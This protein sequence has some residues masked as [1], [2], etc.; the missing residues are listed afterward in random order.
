MNAR[1]DRPH[2]TAGKRLAIAALG[3][4][5]GLSAVFFGRPILS[6]FSRTYVGAGGDPTQA[7]WALVWWPYALRHGLNPFFTD[8]IWAPHGANLAWVTGVPG[9]SLMAAPI[10]LWAGPVAAY[11]ILSLLAPALAATMAYLVCRHLT[12]R[13]WPSLL[14][15]YL[16][17]FSPYE[18][19]HLRG[20][21]NLMLIF[22]IPLAAYLV[23]LRL[24]EAIGPRAFALLLGGVL[25]TQF[26]FSSE[27]F[28]TLSVFGALALGL[29][30]V[31][32]PADLKPRLRSAGVLILC[33]YGIALILLSPYLYS[34]VAQGIPR[35]P[36]SDPD[37]YASDLLN[38]VIPT[39]LTLIGGAALEPIARTFRGNYAE[40]GA[41][42]GVPLLL[43]VALFARSHGRRP[44]GRLLLCAL[45]AVA[46]A[47]LGPALHVAGQRI[48]PLPWKLALLLPVLNN[49]LPGR[50]AVYTS[51]VIAVIVALWL[52]A[53]RVAAPKQWAL[54]GLGAVFLLPNLGYPGWAAPAATPAFIADKLYRAHLHE[55]DNVLVIPFG[56]NG[57]SMLW[58][59]EAGM[60]F[61]MAA[62]YGTGSLP[63]DFFRWPIAY[64]FYSGR[65]IP[66]YAA[67]L[68]AYLA[69]HGVQEIVVADGTPGPW[70]QLF[71]SLGTDPVKT[72]GVV[73][74]R[75][76]E[77]L[78]P[79]GGRVTPLEIERRSTLAL[80]A[81]L[82]T[83][84]DYYVSRGIALAE[85]TPL[86]A[87]QRG[88]L[89][90]YWG[91]YVASQTDAGRGLEFSTR[92][93][94]RLGPWDEDT[95][96]VGLVVS[97]QTVG[98]LNARY[99]SIATR[100][101]F[102]Y[103]RPFSAELT[104]GDGVVLMV[105]TRDGIRRAAAVPP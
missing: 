78:L 28:A 83:A 48:A 67:Q 103:P 1:S 70:P 102:P 57:K 40:E 88:L 27:I 91:G 90:Q 77:R 94:L 52:S 32:L 85:I 36:I 92:T 14:A 21:L 97:G 2:N 76:P 64:T 18:L 56:A 13:F 54:A 60:Y 66:G 96:G 25:C 10:T 34:V 84:A 100:V 42:L 104:R 71:G 86:D 23:L 75:V 6:H 37:A 53:A 3:I 68:R 65:L 79:A 43:V 101:Y 15:G 44:A 87:E 29:A 95:V 51:F 19:G 17:G 49:A 105:F 22:P 39:P 82:I 55:G 9:A 41:Y 62:G 12:R 81:S 46:L 33:A 4:Y 47:S 99:G 11:N 50:F 93:G 98:P 69:A 7:M 63:R 8:R 58:Q 20:H 31:L 72:G 89:P 74:Y 38:L 24:D 73:L 59:A 45:G 30:Y 26:L 16:F 5:A 61:R 35:T 80:A